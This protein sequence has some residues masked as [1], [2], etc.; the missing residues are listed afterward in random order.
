MSRNDTAWQRDLA[1]TSAVTLYSVAVGVGFARVFSGWPF[2]SD[3]IVIAVLGH[4]LSFAL[5]RARV[6]GWLAVPAVSLAL[7]WVL[8]FLNYRD[9]MSGGIVP[10]SATWDQ[11]RIDLSLV[12]DQFP[13]AIAPV[14]YTAGWA[15]LAGFALALVLVMSD[16]F[17]FRA[18]ARGEALVPGGVLFVFIAALGSERLRIASTGFLIAAGVVAVI[19]LRQLHGGRRAPAVT[20]GR[21]ASLVAP[22]AIATAVAIAVV[23]G[24][25]GPRIPGAN[26]EP[27]YDTKGRGGATNVLN[28]L[29]DIRS[30]L[31][32][33]GNVE[34]FRVNADAPAYWR[35]MTLA[36]FDGQQFELPRRSLEPV[37]DVEPDPAA[38]RIRQQVQIISLGGEMVPAAA[39]PIA[40]SGPTPDA[41][42]RRE[43]QS[44]TLFA[45]EPLQPGDVFEIVSS[46]PE[47]TADDLRGRT[48]QAPPDPIYLE[49]PDDL[50][51]VVA[52]TAQA[53]TAGATTPYDQARAMQAWFRD[54]SQWTYSTEVQSGH[55]SNAIESFFRERIGYCEQF[56]ATF[57]AMAR[58]LGIP[59]RVAVGFTP[60]TLSPDGWYSVIG[61]NAH[62]WP[63]LWF[64]GIGWVAFE[65][66][67]GRGAPGLEDVTGLPPQQDTSG[68]DVVGGGAAGSDTLP[69]NPTTPP[70]VVQPDDAS[71]GPPTTVRTP[72][73]GDQ[74]LPPGGFNPNQGFPFEDEIVDGAAATDETNSFPWRTLVVAGLI[75]LALSTPALLRR[76]RRA[77]AGSLPGREQIVTAWERAR[78]AAID[79]GVTGTPAMTPNEWALATATVLPVAARPMTSL[80]DT[81]DRV[82]FAPPGAV[83]LERRG[84][85]G[86]AVTDDCSLWADQVRRIAVDTMSTPQRV[87]RYFTDKG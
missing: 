74:E 30:R 44:R 77:R 39:D 36:E 84:T 31:T 67:P 42:M 8:A 79:A 73:A 16:S 56:S 63:E 5:R 68:P 3:V 25:V 51:S 54:D 24:I 46:A 62:A 60:G 45:P 81:V 14:A 69:P 10:W 7:L 59:S 50:P 38:R 82:A 64:D 85:L 87:K 40:V 48:A 19:A 34:L 20:V 52:E 13:T 26:A 28:P 75:A 18:E 70:T 37:A 4:G 57:A 71:G 27:L 47:L 80:A 6:T 83:D 32:N 43:P 78:T 29:V 65:P 58:T 49:L 66:T 76:A 72:S 12:R 17:A 33:R 41:R 35:V 2:L 1:A 61:K 9:T 11:M 55:G 15:T 23:A 21:R 53:V 86:D 22:A